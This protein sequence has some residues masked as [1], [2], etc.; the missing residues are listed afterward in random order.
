MS[1]E[2]I[3]LR[4]EVARLH[5]GDEPIDD[6]GLDARLG[7]RIEEAEAVRSW[8]DRLLA[9]GH[10]RLNQADLP[11]AVFRELCR[12]I[13]PPPDEVLLDL[14]SGYGRLGFY[15]SLLRGGRIHGIERVQERVDEAS[16]V[17]DR[18]GLATLSFASGDAVTAPWPETGWY[19]VLNSFLPS[20][21]PRVVDRLGEIARRRRIVIAS[22]SMSNLVFA[23]Q[24]WLAE[25]PGPPLAVPSSQGLR[26]FASEG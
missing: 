3:S 7:L 11:Y 25:I 12:R 20:V 22:I 1:E 14:G 8:T 23:Q 16:R 13:E 9:Y 4:R 24:P 10:H 15:G 18:L 17:R 2:T 6:P 26:L 19:C 21:L 5:A